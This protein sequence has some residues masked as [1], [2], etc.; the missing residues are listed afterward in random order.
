MKIV[1]ASFHDFFLPGEIKYGEQMDVEREKETI[2]GTQG[3]NWEG[4]KG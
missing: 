3:M 1:E 4:I 2:T